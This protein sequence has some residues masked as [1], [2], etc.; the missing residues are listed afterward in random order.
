VGQVPVTDVEQHDPQAVIAG[1][2]IELRVRPQAEVQM[3]E[4]TKQTG[5]VV[6]VTG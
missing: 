5:Q 2:L 3:S 4:Q 1:G 6:V